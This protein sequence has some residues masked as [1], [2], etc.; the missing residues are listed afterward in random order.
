MSTSSQWPFGNLVDLTITLVSLS[1]QNDSR[2][3]AQILYLICST[4]SRLKMKMILLI[5]SYRK[6][7]GSDRFIVEVCVVLVGCV[8]NS[9]S[10]TADV[11]NLVFVRAVLEKASLQI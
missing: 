8:V 3:F 9:S 11:A 5:E 7:V 6:E 10:V 1:Q 2:G 4:C